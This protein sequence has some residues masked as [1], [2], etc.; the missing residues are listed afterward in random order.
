LGGNADAMGG[1]VMVVIVILHVVEQIVRPSRPEVHIT[2]RHPWVFH[3][4]SPNEVMLISEARRPILVGGQQKTGIL[5]PSSGKDK[6]LCLHAGPAAR[7]G[8]QLNASNNVTTIRGD[9]DSIG[10]EID[11]DMLG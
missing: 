2:R 7:Q 3:E 5:N 4:E 8:F 11:G 1:N 10:I 6:N 9:I